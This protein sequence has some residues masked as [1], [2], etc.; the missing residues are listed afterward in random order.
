MFHLNAVLRDKGYIDVENGAVT[1]WRGYAHSCSLSAQIYV[2]PG[3][4][5]DAVYK[6]LLPSRR[7]IRR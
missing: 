2:A 1:G 7:N 4:D 3:V 6:D 5:E